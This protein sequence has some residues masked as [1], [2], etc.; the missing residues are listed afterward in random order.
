MFFLLVNFF[1]EQDK[2][3]YQK[4]LNLFSLWT[5]KSTKYLLKNFHHKTFQIKNQYPFNNL[6]HDIIKKE[7]IWLESSFGWQ[8]NHDKISYPEQWDAH[9]SQWTIKQM[10]FMFYN[11]L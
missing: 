9:L 8:R 10:P 4:D 7:P 5:S 1:T 6:R 3:V 2:R 11:F